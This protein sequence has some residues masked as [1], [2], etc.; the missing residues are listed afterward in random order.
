MTLLIT[1]PLVFRAHFRVLVC[2]LL[3]AV[4]E[5]PSKGSRADRAGGGRD[6][7]RFDGMEDALGVQYRRRGGYEG[8]IRP[9]SRLQPWSP[10]LVSRFSANLSA[11]D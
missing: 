8:T 2:C 7:R 5:T 4:R 3:R 11:R 1:R 6:R 10:R 9:V